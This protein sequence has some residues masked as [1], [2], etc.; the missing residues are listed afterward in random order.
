MKKIIRL[1][2]SDLHNIIRRAINEAIGDDGINDDV[3]EILDNL[4]QNGQLD[5]YFVDNDER[6]W[7]RLVNDILIN[8]FDYPFSQDTMAEAESIYNDSV[9]RWKE[10]YKMTDLMGRSGMM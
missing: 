4:Y 7:I 6:K 2:E 10:G 5:S 3:I 9:I 1:T 8:R